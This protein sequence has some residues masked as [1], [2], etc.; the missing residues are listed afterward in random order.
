MKQ[1]VDDLIKLKFQVMKRIQDM[2]TRKNSI[3]GEKRRLERKLDE[4]GEDDTDDTA[5]NS[6]VRSLLL[7]HLSTY[8]IPLYSF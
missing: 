3:E 7:F 5:I 4:M 1:L 2:D 8:L 6:L